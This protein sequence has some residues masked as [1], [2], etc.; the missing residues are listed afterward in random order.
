MPRREERSELADVRFREATGV[1]VQSDH[2]NR[3]AVASAEHEDRE[4]NEANVPIADAA[5]HGAR[6]SRGSRRPRQARCPPIL[7]TLAPFEP[8]STGSRRARRRTAARAR[9]RRFRQRRASSRT[10]SH[11]WSEHGVPAGAIVA[12]TFTNKAAAEMR[13]R[14]TKILGRERGRKGAATATGR[15]P[16]R[17][18]TRSALPC[19]GKSEAPSA[20]ASPFSIKATKRPS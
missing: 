5:E 6:E 9:G 10:A 17:R 2:G 12:L 3:H 8:R 20:A 13:A 11:V 7:F 18:F 19:S 1:Q 16:S 14:V 4:V 15:S